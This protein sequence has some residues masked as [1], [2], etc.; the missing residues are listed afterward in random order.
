MN[1]KEYMVAELNKLTKLL[2]L[3]QLEQIEQNI[4]RGVSFDLGFRAL[5]GGQVL[6]QALMAANRTVE[7]ERQAHSM[8][9][10][11][12]RAG[13]AKAPI[14]YQVTRTRDGRSFT[15]RHV[16]AIQHGQPIFDMSVSYQTQEDGFEHQDAMPTGIPEPETLKSFREIYGAAEDVPDYVRDQMTRD[17]PVEVRPVNVIEK[18]NPTPREALKYTWFRAAGEVPDDPRLHQ[19]VLAYASDFELLGTSMLPHGVSFVQKEIQ[20]ASLD[21]ALWIHR[22]FRVD[23]WLLYRMNSSNMSNARG[24]AHGQIFSRDGRL[25]ASVMQ[26]GLVRRLSPDWKRNG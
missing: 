11:F 9:A 3:F 22:P 2:E 7:A 6:G 20:A 26:E 25:V 14:V 16:L 8:H 15:T 12:L 5:F 23:E 10:Y 19:A 18:I 1:K 13:D 21:H 17:R 24:L 4:F